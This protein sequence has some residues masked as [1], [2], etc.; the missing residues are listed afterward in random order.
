MHLNTSGSWWHN[1]SARVSHHCDQGWVPAP[2]SYQIKV[3]LVTSENVVQFDSPNIADYIRV[4]RFP[5]V[6]TLDPLGVA[7]TGSLGRT[8]QLTDRVIQF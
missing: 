6:V 7:P 3:T 4:L 8:T 2:C 1:S 5:P